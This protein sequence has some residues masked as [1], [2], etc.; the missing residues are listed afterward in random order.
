MQNMWNPDADWLHQEQRGT[1][2]ATRVPLESNLWSGAVCLCFLSLSLPHLIIPAP[3]KGN[4][5]K[6]NLLKKKSIWHKRHENM[7]PSCFLWLV[8]AADGAV[9]IV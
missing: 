5:P 2:V 4:P 3:N 7:D 1:P 8:Q 9:S 6:K